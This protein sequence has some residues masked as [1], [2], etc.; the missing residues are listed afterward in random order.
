MKK[1]KHSVLYYICRNIYDSSCLAFAFYLCVVS[2][3]VI[4][5]YYGFPNC[6][7]NVCWD[8]KSI[9]SAND[10]IITICSGYL[11]TYI[12]YLLTVAIPNAVKTQYKRVALTENARELKD[13]SYNLLNQLC[14]FCFEQDE[15]TY[16]NFMVFFA[17]N[18]TCIFEYKINE[19]SITIINKYLDKFH[20]IQFFLEKDLEHLY[21]KER[22]CLIAMETA[23]MWKQTKQLAEGCL[24]TCKQYENYLSEIFK[25][26]KL[27]KQLF[28]IMN[29]TNVYSMKSFNLFLYK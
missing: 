21:E 6:R 24:Y 19:S 17:R 11:V 18:C 10:L 22:L 16:D 25:Y 20:N 9:K 7:F 2:L 28:E 15:L 14:E 1:F 4:I 29:S 23:D 26:Y 8:A 5:L 3:I 27:A 12:A 13:A